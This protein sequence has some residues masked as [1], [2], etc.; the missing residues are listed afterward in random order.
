M[1]CLSFAERRGWFVII[2]LLLA[3]QIKYMNTEIREWFEIIWLVMYVKIKIWRTRRILDLIDA[4]FRSSFAC[5]WYFRG[6]FGV[7]YYIIII[8]IIVVVIDI[9]GSM[10]LVEPKEFVV[11]QPWR[12]VYEFSN[13]TVNDISE[14]FYT[15][16]LGV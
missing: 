5:I 10:K 6:F 13:G 4:G 7:H 1:T 12:K 9:I 8:V 14:A 2:R 15:M 3:V 16:G 11:F